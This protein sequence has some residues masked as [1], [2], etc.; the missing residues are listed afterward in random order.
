ME[1][2]ILKIMFKYKWYSTIFCMVLYFVLVGFYLRPISLI[3]FF[4]SLIFLLLLILSLW[5]ISFL[6]LNSINENSSFGEILGRGILII[7]YFIV[8][9]L[10][11]II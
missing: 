11:I 8:L 2:I 3:N 4:G 6:M 1:K 7:S 10:V 9:I 5:N